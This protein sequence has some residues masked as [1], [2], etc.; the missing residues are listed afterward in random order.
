MT[1]LWFAFLFHVASFQPIAISSG[2][3]VGHPCAVASEEGNF[4]ISV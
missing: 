3:S 4:Y 1:L 2:L